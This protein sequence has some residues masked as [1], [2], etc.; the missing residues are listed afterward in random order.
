MQKWLKNMR[1]AG[2]VVLVS[3][4]AALTA[5]LMQPRPIPAPHLSPS[6]AAVDHQFTG[7]KAGV[8]GANPM[9]DFTVVASNALPAVVHVRTKESQKQVSLWDLLTQPGI[10]EE[11]RGS[12]SGVIL[13]ED[14]YIVTNNHVIKG[15]YEINVTLYN[16]KSFPATVVGVDAENDLAVLKIHASGLPIL[17][18][19]NSDVLRPG[20][21]V[22]AIGYP[23]NLQETVTAGIISATRSTLGSS[24]GQSKATQTFLQ[25]DAAINLGNSGGALINAEGELIGINVALISP[26]G[27]YSGYGYAIPVNKVKSVINKLIQTGRAG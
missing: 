14:G 9:D 22:L 12:G 20:N 26:T 19:G 4:M 16:N 6:P 10:V 7:W 17:V 25:T 11:T 1:I 13:S 5:V 27:A 18:Y 2:L 21:W 3:A 23:F 8:G 24:E 15:A